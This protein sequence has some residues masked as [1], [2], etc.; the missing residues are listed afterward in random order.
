M[1][2]CKMYVYKIRVNSGKMLLLKIIKQL[3]KSLYNLRQWPFL[4]GP[5]QA[6]FCRV[7]LFG[8]EMIPIVMFSW[9]PY[10]SK[11]FPDS[12]NESKCDKAYR[13]DPSGHT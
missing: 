2:V 6:S 13:A 8:D 12:L 11:L 4:V 5:P 3:H 10:R 9:A 7:W 1:Y